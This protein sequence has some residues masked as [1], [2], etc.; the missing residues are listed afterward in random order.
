MAR[1]AGEA[2]ETRA[3]EPQELRRD[4][5][6]LVGSIFQGIT[7]MA[8]AAGVMTGI[9]FI[10]SSAGSA[11]PLAFVL[12][13]IISLLI[14]A[15][16]NQ[17]AKHLPS[18][19]GYYTYV[20]RGINPRVG[21]MTGWI[22]FLYDPLIPNLCTL[23]TA[24]YVSST[25]QDLFGFPVPWWL[26]AI[27]VY[28]GLGLITYLG[29]QPSIRTAIAFTTIE[30]A[31]TLL[32]SIVLFATHGISGH[33]VAQSFT[34][35]GVP[36]GFQGLA[37]GMIFTVLS[38]TGFES[39][40]PLAEET[41]NPRVNIARAAVLS[42]VFII[43]YYAIFSFATIVGWGPDRMG[44]LIKDSAPYNT[45]ANATWGKAGVALLTL[46]LMNSG[47]GC[48][49]AGQNAVVRVLYK[50]GQVGVLPKAFASVHPRYQSPH[51]AVFA[52]TALSFVVLVLL[53]VWLGPIGGFGLL[54]TMIGLGTILVY[55]LGM[56]AV[57]IYYR[58]EHPEETN[59]FLTYLFPIVGTLM[60]IPVLYAS[61]YPPPAFP[62]NLAPYIDIVWI[63]IGVVT[64]VW[65]NRT[66]PQQLQAGAEA[67]F[68]ETGAGS[69]LAR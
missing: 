42:V 46:A 37:F 69:D 63:L 1:S 53:G 35:S 14:A 20:S 29:I 26:Y 10:A 61:V 55:A 8:P 36:T 33:A 21:F 62:L 57:P 47:W 16:I 59:V 28:L 32:F 6:G 5:V 50:M 45:L 60:L 64:V 65:L 27:V 17:M 12:A 15:S 54:A 19:G 58:R 30:V 2:A 44:S 3:G 25:V 68:A 23:V 31:I 9:G 43:V 13:G 40:I 49:L 56:I 11:I 22:Y 38:Y 18:A 51:V 66:R 41:R 67:I 4:V 48:S 52:M 7:H 39:T 34:L 24:A